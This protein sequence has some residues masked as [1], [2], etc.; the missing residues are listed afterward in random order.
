[1]PVHDHV[2]RSLINR[3][4]TDQ[5]GHRRPAKPACMTPTR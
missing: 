3:P 5:A 2:Q 4:A 1:V